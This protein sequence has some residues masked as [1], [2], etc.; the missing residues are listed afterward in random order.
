MR[1]G[2]PTSMLFLFLVLLSVRFILASVNWGGSPSVD[3]AQAFGQVGREAQAAFRRSD[4][5]LGVLT[6]LLTG[7]ALV[8][9]LSPEGRLAA[10]IINAASTILSFVALTAGMMIIL[11]VISA[12]AEPARWPDAAILSWI[13]GLIAVGAVLSTRFV[14]STAEQLARAEQRLN[15]LGDRARRD[16]GNGPAVRSSHSAARAHAQI[17]AWFAI[18]VVAECALLS[19]ESGLW[20]QNYP[21]WTSLLAATVVLPT[22]LWLWGTYVRTKSLL[23]PVTTFILY[24]LLFLGGAMI[25]AV[26]AN[27]YF[28]LER[29][30]LRWGLAYTIPL[31]ILFATAATRVPGPLSF[32]V[33]LLRRRAIDVA[34]DAGVRRRDELRAQ[35]IRETGARE[36]TLTGRRW[37]R[38]RKQPKPCLETNSASRGC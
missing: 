34:I 15:V 33:R 17:V 24:V 13:A 37:G 35:F 27:G 23:A 26:F 9:R 36:S 2:F 16:Y 10:P 28:H 12:S 32:A 11:F 25:A 8:T 38:G 30:G 6:T 3:L 29:V 5:V 7:I 1:I 4:L 22:S 19:A 21:Q 31:L 18:V 20:W 14:S